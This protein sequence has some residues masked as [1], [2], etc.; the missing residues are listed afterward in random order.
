VRR[1]MPEDQGYRLTKS[2]GVGHTPWSLPDEPAAID[3]RDT[4][5]DRGRRRP[6]PEWVG[7][8]ANRARVRQSAEGVVA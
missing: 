5:V 8:E 6:A 1:D 7:R 4:N 2:P 3:S